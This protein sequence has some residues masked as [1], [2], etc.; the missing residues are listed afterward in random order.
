ML[1]LAFIRMCDLWLR[2]AQINFLLEHSKILLSDYLADAIFSL[3]LHTK[4]ENECIPHLYQQIICSNQTDRVLPN[5]NL[6]VKVSSDFLYVMDI[7]LNLNAIHLNSIC[8]NSIQSI[9]IQSVWFQSILN[10]IIRIANVLKLIEFFV[11]IN[12]DVNNLHPSISNKSLNSS[13]FCGN[14]YLICYLYT[15]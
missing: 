8:L 2:S 14:T 11:E 4:I 7:H 6:H 5:I 1:C 15:E 12:F 3:C 10:A 13:I 9:W